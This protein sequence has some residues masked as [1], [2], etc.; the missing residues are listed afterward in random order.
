MLP[1]EVGSHPVV[2]VLFY[3]NRHYRIARVGTSTLI[4]IFK[5]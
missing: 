3:C 1:E 5:E 4:L 2:R